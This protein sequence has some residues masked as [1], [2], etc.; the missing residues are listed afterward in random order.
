[1]ETLPQNFFHRRGIDHEIR[2]SRATDDEI[3]HFEI[4]RKIIK[5]NGITADSFG[6][7]HRALKGPIGNHKRL[8]AVAL[9]MTRQQI[10][11]FTCPNQHNRLVVESIE[12]A[13][14]QIHRDRAHRH[15]ATTDAGLAAHP[16]RHREGTME[17]AVQDRAHRSRLLRR[18]VILF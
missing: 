9:Q 8:H 6:Q 3:G 13:P 16:F 10:A 1:M 4:A 5:T 15:R 2:H 17:Q 11:H 12:N 18:V 7:R 14:C